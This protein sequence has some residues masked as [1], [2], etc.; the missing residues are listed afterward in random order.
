MRD[1]EESALGPREYGCLVTAKQTATFPKD[2]KKGSPKNWASLETRV[3]E[4][5]KRSEDY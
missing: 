1:V 4:R 2:M 5:A 3:I